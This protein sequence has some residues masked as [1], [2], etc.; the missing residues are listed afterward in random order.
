MPENREKTA[1]KYEYERPYVTRPDAPAVHA[2][3]YRAENDNSRYCL[4]YNGVNLIAF[5][6]DGEKYPGVRAHSDGDFQST[7]MVQQFMI[8]GGKNT[9][10]EVTFRAPVEMWNMKPRRAENGEAILGQVGLPLMYG[11]N[12][13]YLP[14]WDLLIS[15][16]GA[17]FKWLGTEITAEEGSWSADMSVSAGDTPWIVLLRPHY[18]SEHLGYCYHRPWKFRPNPKAVT[19]WCSWEAYHGSVTEKDIR[20]AAQKLSFLKNYGM[21]YMQLDD[22]Y[23]Q[24]NVP[25]RDDGDVP[26]S[27][28][29]TNERFPGGHEEI[30]SAMKSGG[31]QPGIWTNATVTNRSGAEK[32][33]CCL[34]DKN[35]SLIQ[36]DWIQ[37]P[38]DCTAETLSRHVEPYFRAFR[39]LGYKY[40][41]SD[42]IRHLIYDGLQEAVRLGVMEPETARERQRAYMEAAR[43][44]LGDDIYYLSCWGVLSQSI[45]VADAM[46][47]ATDTNP[48]WQAYSMQLRETA[49]WFFAQRVM[50]TVDPDMVCVRGPVKWARM[51]LSLVALTG[52]LF[53][54]SDK[55]EDYDEERLA[56]I[57]KTMPGLCTRAA[58]TGP[59][60]YTTPACVP[61]PRESEAGEGSRK[62]CHFT[63][64]EKNPFASLW[65]THFRLGDRRWAV[66]QRAGV[67]PLKKTRL[68]VSSLSLDPEKRYYAY[69][70]W[71]DRGFYIENG[72]IT[73][74]GLEL[75]DTA[76]IALTDISENKP[77]LVASDRHV[78]MDAVSV[79]EHIRSGN[80]LVLRL[81]GFEGL[82]VKYTL[83]VPGGAKNV[84]ADGADISYRNNGDITAVTVTFRGSEAVLSIH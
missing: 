37:F 27:W 56:L 60:D 29:T 59:I 64:N 25:V 35:G 9:E 19:G 83:F 24:E 54:I 26:E 14:D 43:R 18:Y 30:V 3:L 23:Q 45:G 57:R 51:A 22:G 33:G 71:N 44:S 11:V 53:M 17:P 66:L 81:K 58:E 55:P 80:G 32:M 61:M 74:P 13:M 67:T 5:K 8:C 39:D 46:R 76:V 73:L 10:I 82:R 42:S 34:R 78:S 28:L 15:W 12:G 4:N 70:Y 41:K 36:G 52:G 40:V 50:F 2:R 1:V 31:F 63:G 48:H 68:S 77:V 65:C 49:R 7:P 47:I 69:D 72:F 84:S 75:G 20:N 62:M 79:S 21:E 6:I 16:H 38:L